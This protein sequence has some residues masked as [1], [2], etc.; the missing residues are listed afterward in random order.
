IH[1]HHRRRAEAFGR[2]WIGRLHRRRGSDGAERRRNDKIIAARRALELDGVA[3]LSGSSDERHQSA[4]L[5]ALGTLRILT[6][7]ADAEHLHRQVHGGPDGGHISGGLHTVHV[8][9]DISILGMVDSVRELL[10]GV[11][12]GGGYGIAHCGGENAENQN[13]SESNSKLSNWHPSGGLR[14]HHSAS[15]FVLGYR[16]VER[17]LPLTAGEGGVE[18]SVDIGL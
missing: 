9:P 17:A 16:A 7:H 14:L 6:M 2:P 10:G 12:G 15:S 18:P 4:A 1:P 13:R 11:A 5:P 3:I 8:R